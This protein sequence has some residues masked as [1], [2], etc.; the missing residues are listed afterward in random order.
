M[1]TQSRSLLSVRDLDEN[2]LNEI[3]SQAT[4]FRERFQSSGQFVDASS[5]K[6]NKVV[7]EAFFE[8]STRTRYSFQIAAQRLGLNCVGMDLLSGSSMNKGESIPET[9][10]TIDAMQAD[11]VVV[12]SKGGVEVDECIRSMQSPVINAGAGTFGHPTQA[13][14]DTYTLKQHLPSLEGVNLLMVG[15]ITHSRVAHSNLR[16]L[17]HYGVQIGVCGPRRFLPSSEEWQD[18]K[19]FEKLDDGLKWARVVMAFRIQVERHLV[20]GAFDRDHYASEYCL[21]PF[22]MKSLRQDGFLLHPGPFVAGLDLSPAVL[23]DSR[24]LIREQVSNGVY[25]RAAILKILLDL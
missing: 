13:I 12:R 16:V 11:I 14:L 19:V 18:V 22:R 2:S 8:P 7:A 17:R 10:R 4:V 20:S 25:V 24:C 9:L 15:D 1:A 3:F 21:T 5:P 23:S 6:P